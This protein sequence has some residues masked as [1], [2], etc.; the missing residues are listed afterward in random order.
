MFG[1]YEC[2]GALSAVRFPL[3]AFTSKGFI[4]D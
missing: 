2:V 1:G 3:Y 4:Y